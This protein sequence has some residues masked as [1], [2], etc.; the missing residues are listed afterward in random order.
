MQYVVETAAA[1]VNAFKFCV[2][3]QYMCVWM[4][5]TDGKCRYDHQLS[6]GSHSGGLVVSDTATIVTADKQDLVVNSLFFGISDTVSGFEG[7]K[8]VLGLGRSASS[9]TSQVDPLSI[10]YP[11]AVGARGCVACRQFTCR[12]SGSEDH[13][14][15]L[16]TEF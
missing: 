6:D 15:S 9:F 10:N 14:Q 4:L 3:N 11:L 7:R 2:V 5:M 8:G 13:L 16:K 1:G 12:T